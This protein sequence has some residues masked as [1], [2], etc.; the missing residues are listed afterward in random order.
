MKIMKKGGYWEALARKRINE[1]QES[2]KK[3]EDRN[4]RRKEEYG[5]IDKIISSMEEHYK[6]ILRAEGGIK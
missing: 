3:I 1:A 4:R 5:Y 6:E 2:V